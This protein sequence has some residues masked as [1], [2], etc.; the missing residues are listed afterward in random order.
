MLKSLLLRHLA[1]L[2]RPTLGAV[3]VLLWD[4]F[5]RSGLRE[6]ENLIR[7]QGGD[8][9]ELEPYPTDAGHP[10]HVQAARTELESLRRSPAQFD[11]LALSWLKGLDQSLESRRD[12]IYDLAEL[13][14][15]C[16]CSYWLRR[17]DN[18]IAEHFAEHPSSPIAPA[19]EAGDSL[20]LFPYCLHQIAV[21]SAEISGRRI[22]ARGARK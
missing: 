7:R 4:Y 19:A 13:P 9:F 10:S 18:L 17:R 20:S 14:G 12:K 15:L 22:D 2:H 3:Y 6:A 5:T 16:G 21:P 1:H 8:S 11:L